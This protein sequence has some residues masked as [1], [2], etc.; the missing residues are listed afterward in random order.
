M[1]IAVLVVVVM[2]TQLP[3]SL[4]RARLSPDVVAIALIW[5]AGLALTQRVG[6]GKGLPWQDGGEAPDSQ[7]SRGAT[8]ATPAQLRQ[9][10]TA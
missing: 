3:V 5:V 4:V 7:P 9:A 10:G 8:P 1:V 6:V 2:G